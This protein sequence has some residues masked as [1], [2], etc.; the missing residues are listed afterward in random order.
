MGHTVCYYI[1]TIK[2]VR[3]INMRRYRGGGMLSSAN[4]ALAAIFIAIIALPITGLVMMFN[5]SQE[6]KALGALLFV[7]GLIVCAAISR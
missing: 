2:K 3:R 6:K 1:V 7:V 4:G 5:G